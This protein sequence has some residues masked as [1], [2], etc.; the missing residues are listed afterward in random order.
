MQSIYKVAALED[1]PDLR[2]RAEEHQGR[3][4]APPFGEHP[5]TRLIR[6][7]RARLEAAAIT[8]G[9]AFRAVDRHG[10]VAVC[11]PAGARRFPSVRHARRDQ[12]GLDRATQL[13]DRHGYRD[14]LLAHDR[15]QTLNRLRG[16][17]FE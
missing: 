13:E 16:I 1:R 9:S 6:A 5:D 15:R 14:S 12:R 10:H 2:S 17:T 3:T 4:F 11:P 8:S 7:L